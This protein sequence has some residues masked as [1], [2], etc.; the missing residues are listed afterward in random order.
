MWLAFY[1]PYNVQEFAFAYTCIIICMPYWISVEF[2]NAAMQVPHFD[3]VEFFMCLWLWCPIQYWIRIVLS[4]YGALHW[5]VQPNRH[6]L[7]KHLAT[8]INLLMLII[9]YLLRC[10]FKES[11]YVH[12]V[13]DVQGNCHKFDCLSYSRIFQKIHRF[14][15]DQ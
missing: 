6:T 14:R 11:A 4:L 3:V 2:T 12:R 1:D 7:H 13:L 8:V 9:W 10:C 15:V 5:I